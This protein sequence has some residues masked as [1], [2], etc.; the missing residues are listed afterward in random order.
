[1]EDIKDW[2]IGKSVLQRMKYMLDN[3]L[4]CDVTFHVGTDKTPIQA[5]KYMLASSSP[6]FYSM[7]D[8]PVAEKGNVIIP[9]I[10]PETFEIIL[11]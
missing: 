10:E 2:Q 3:Q 11:K 7:F 9:D 5:H 8:G 4:M 1:M 6:V